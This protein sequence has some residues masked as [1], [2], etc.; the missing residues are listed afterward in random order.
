MGSV[1]GDAAGPPAEVMWVDPAA[2]TITPDETTGSDHYRS[3]ADTLVQHFEEVLHDDQ[4]TDGVD[5]VI[6]C[7]HH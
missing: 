6:R 4:F 1:E 2:K 3:I 7:P 5:L